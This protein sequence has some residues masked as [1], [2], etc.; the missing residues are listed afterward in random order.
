MRP[1]LIALA[2]ATVVVLS[3]VGGGIWYARRPAPP[4]ITL[5]RQVRPQLRIA[6]S[7]ITATGTVKLKSGADVRVGAQISGI[8]EELN[9]NVGSHVTAGQVIAVLDTRAIRATIAEAE[10]TLA[11]DQAVLVKDTRN[12]ARLKRLLATH[13]VSLQQADDALADL[14]AQRATVTFAKSNLVAAK[15]NLSYATIRAPVSGIVASVSTQ[16][17]E[18]VAAAF[19]TP[20]F[21]TIIQPRALE[22]VAMVDEA[23]IGPV[24]VGQPV[25]FTTETY[26]DRPFSGRVTRIAP[27]ATII[28]GVV[29][30]EVASSIDGDVG[31][32]RPEMTATA[33]IHTAEDR[34]FFAPA[35]ARRSPLERRERGR[36]RAH[37]VRT[38]AAP[39]DRPRLEVGVASRDITRP[40]P[41][42]PFRNRGAP[43][44]IR[45][46]HIAKEYRRAEEHVIAI[47]DADFAVHAGEFVVIRGR[48]GSGKSSLLN[49]IGCLD[50]A[51]RGQYLLEDVEVNGMSDASL[52]QVRALKIGFI[53]Q[54]FHLL[55]RTSA[56]E[57]VELPMVYAGRAP[58]RAAALTALSRVG[59]ADRAD[60]YPSQLSGGEQQRVAVARAL[61]NDPAL[62]L[63]DEPTGNLDQAA[64]EAVMELLQRL[65][66][67]GRTIVLVTH[68]D[69]V[70]AYAGRTLSI[71]D[72][73]VTE[74]KAS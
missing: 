10:A 8:V 17:G 45:L 31:S 47:R 12:D 14:I 52:S 55:P 30:Y 68:D 33:S 70:A 34:G 63:A 19:S 61:I 28:S 46:Q 71:E 40:E 38:L 24:R 22:M 66:R 2:A 25:T 32:L 4:P 18:T 54:S 58:D 20:T 6:S 1:A 41:H 59:L 44:M 35:A 42:E 72:G 29:N 13:D 5:V 39:A 48:S 56:A 57:N 36:R 67:E 60:H 11:K 26:P 9:V 37:G 65:N 64:G 62:I 15:L 3:L 43:L 74:G 73:V 53:F 69:M 21:V 7:D 23:D 27:T 51:S 16:Q 49:I 50:H